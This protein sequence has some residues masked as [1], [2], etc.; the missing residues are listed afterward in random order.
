MMNLIMNF[1]CAS[2]GTLCFAILYNVHKR[3]YLSVSGVGGVGFVVYLL[4][5]DITS[6]AMATFFGTIVVVLLSRILAV[7]MKCPITIFLVSG[8][9][10]LLPSPRIYYTAFYIMKNQPD[11]AWIHG[12]YAIQIVFSIVIAIAFVLSIPRTKFV[13]FK[14]K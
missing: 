11:I 9:L 14:N 3:Y 10:A 4:L 6:P 13:L 8:I 1:I 7:Y 12:L 5:V 2:I